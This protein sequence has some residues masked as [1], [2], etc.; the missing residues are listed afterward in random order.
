MIY[1][2]A[3]FFF[4]KDISVHIKLKSNTWLNGIIKELPDTKDRLILEEEFFGEMPPIFF[5]TIED[6]GIQKRMEKREVEK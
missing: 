4:I 6:D 5:D 2:T 3:K 1:E